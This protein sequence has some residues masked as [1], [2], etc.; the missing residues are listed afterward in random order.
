MKNFNLAMV[1]VCGV[2]LLTTIY[3]YFEDEISLTLFSLV[4][5][6]LVISIGVFL[7]RLKL[8]SKK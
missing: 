8:E 1:F 7:G 4:L 6:S 2:L 3:V 5:S